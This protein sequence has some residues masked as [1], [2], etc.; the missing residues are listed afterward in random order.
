MFFLS[1]LNLLKCRFL[2]KLVLVQNPQIKH[3]FNIKEGYI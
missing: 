1:K 2:C 3:S